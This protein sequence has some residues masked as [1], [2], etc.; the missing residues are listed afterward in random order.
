MAKTKAIETYAALS[1]LTAEGMRLSDAVRQLAADT[2]RSE[3]AIRASYY[4]QRV[5]LGLHGRRPS[6]TPISVEETV[7]QARQLLE[8]TLADIDEELEAAKADADAAQARYEQLHAKAMEMRSELQGKIAA[9]K[10]SPTPKKGGTRQ[11]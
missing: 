3:S 5:K 10:P 2:G 7:R 11:Q 8:Q 1:K 9:L 6:R 4:Q